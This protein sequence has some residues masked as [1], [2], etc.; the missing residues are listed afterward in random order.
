[1]Q[2]PSGRLLAALVPAV[3]AMAL[4]ACGNKSQESPNPAAV[5]VDHVPGTRLPRVVLSPEAAARLG[6]RTAR[7][8]VVTAPTGRRSVVIPYAAV[9]YDP[10]GTP[11]TYTTALPRVYVR[12]PVVIARLVGNNA[13]LTRGP[14]SGT[15]VVS[16]GAAELLGSETG[17]EDK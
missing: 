6:V 13:Y 14:R 4:S 15:A 17:V 10:N 3:L 9:I 16:V 12:T 8:R 5:R 2:R 1:M 11:S 7:A